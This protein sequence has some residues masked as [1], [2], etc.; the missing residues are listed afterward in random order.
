MRQLDPLFGVSSST[1][2]RV[3]PTAGSLLS[4]KPADRP[5]EATD[6]LW[7]VYGTLIMLRNRS[8]AASPRNCRLSANMQ[9]IV[10][11]D[12]RLVIAA[13]RV[14]PGT[15]ADAHAWRASTLSQQCEGATVLGDD[16]CSNCRMAV[17]G[18]QRVD[19]DVGA[20]LVGE[21]TLEQMGDPGG[22][23]ASAM[24]LPCSEERSRARQAAGTE[25]RYSTTDELTRFPGSQQSCACTT[26]RRR[27][28]RPPSLGFGSRSR[29]P[30]P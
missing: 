24:V 4:T 3:I 14:A 22:E 5:A 6:R 23:R 27:R 9:V 10:D 26:I 11:A 2:C 17:R 28:R 1:G 7:I 19:V 29:A 16:A 20:G 15:T 30:P 18:A 25:V 8:V 12:T 13:A 21:L